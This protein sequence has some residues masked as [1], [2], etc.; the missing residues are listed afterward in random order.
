MPRVVAVHGNAQQYRGSEILRSEWLPALR[1][2]LARAGRAV[3]EKDDLAC[4]FYGD[5]FR[6]Q[7]S[8][9][10]NGPPYT[11]G[12]LDPWEAALL[13]LWW[14]EAASRDAALPGPDTYTMLRTSRTVQRALNALSATEFFGGLAERF[15]IVFLKQVHRYLSDEATNA[16][17]QARV[18]G[19]IDE[20]TRVVIGHSLGSVVAYES[21]CAHPEW[22][23]ERFVS[24]GSPLGTRMIFERLRPPPWD[25]RGVWP[26]SVRTWVNVADAG[27]IVALVTSLGPRFGDGIVD[28]LVNNGSDAH[29]VVRYLTSREVGEAVGAAF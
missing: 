17:V 7:E 25:G 22:R 6:P 13:E 9:S 16:A 5:L 28:L 1:D 19:V 24:L 20:D 2:G 3:L 27:D 15:M 11:A 26:Q 8:L 21:L 14:R 29:S 4:V 23:I 12:D 18:A 10:L